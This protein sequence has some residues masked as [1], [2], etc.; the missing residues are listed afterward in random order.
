MLCSRKNRKSN[1]VRREKDR[2]MENQVKKFNIF[3]VGLKIIVFLGILLTYTLISGTA[4][5]IL[6]SEKISKL[7]ACLI[8]FGM[9]GGL[10]A[11]LSYVCRK[12]M[13]VNTGKCVK[14]FKVLI[15]IVAYV[16]LLGLVSLLFNELSALI[17]GHYHGT[18]NQNF[19]NQLLRIKQ[20]KW[21]MMVQIGILAPIVEELIFRGILVKW[22]FQNNVKFQWL[23]S[24]G[25]FALMHEQSAILAFLMYFCMGSILFKV[26]RQFGLIG[27]IT[28]HIIYNC[29][30]LIPWV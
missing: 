6:I 13:W 10:I 5:E 15:Y 17:V 27:S 14:W 22:F 7:V 20:I 8:G 3:E 21:F 24:A 19:I 1:I 30:L 28:V 18:I 2:Y 16:I 25:L 9:Y 29:I 12:Q 26:R 4:L 23:L 11:G